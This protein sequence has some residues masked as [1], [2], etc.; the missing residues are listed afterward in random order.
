MREGFLFVSLLLAESCFESCKL[1]VHSSGNSVANLNVELLDVLN[2]LEPALSVNGEQF[3]DCVESNVLKTF[4]ADV[5]SLRK[6]ALL[7]PKV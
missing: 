6:E 7:N 2:I 4:N 5:L 1:V 3:L